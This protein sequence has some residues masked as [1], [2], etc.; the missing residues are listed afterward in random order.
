MYPYLKL[1]HSHNGL[2]VFESV[3]RLLSFSLAANELN[4]TQSAVSRQVKQL[5]QELDS[6]LVIRKH[7][8]IEL[9]QKGQELLFMLSKHYQSLHDTFDTWQST[10]KKRFVIKASL[11]FTTRCLLPKLQDLHERYPEHEIVII[12]SLDD[13][14]SIKDSDYDL[15]IF[16][17]RKRDHY[18]HQA[19]MT[20]LR[21]EYMAPVCSHAASPAIEINSILNLP[22]LHSTL[23]H[24]DWTAWLS[25]QGLKNNQV[26]RNTTFYTLD[27]ALSACLSG[28]GATVTDL[29]LVLPE[30]QR[31]FLLCPTAAKI[32]YSAWQYFCCQH[33]K[34]A[35][36]DEIVS[37]LH[38]QTS[39]DIDTL[40]ALAQT[41]GWE[42]LTPNDV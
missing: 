35:M 23:D 15:L 20:F 34:T 7:R 3:A 12:P 4:V 21:E 41:Q 30:L 16:N 40:R 38:E 18:T 1:P 33:N 13:E 27:L 5:E 31:G 8:E 6:V 10:H 39:Q 36:A 29:L 24:Y 32:Q 37:W 26:V 9:T 19:H 11:S 28:Q 17:T 25:G 2:R 42:G 22:R 14:S